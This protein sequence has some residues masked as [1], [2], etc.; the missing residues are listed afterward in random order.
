MCY[1]TELCKVCGE[2]LNGEPYYDPKMCACDKKTEDRI[3][4]CLNCRGGKLTPQ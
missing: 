4:T 3:Y 1:V 2:D